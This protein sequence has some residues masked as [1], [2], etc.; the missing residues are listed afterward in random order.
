MV[1]TIPARK[2]VGANGM[3]VMP[4]ATVLVVVLALVYMFT[5]SAAGMHTWLL[6]GDID[7]AGALLLG[8]ALLFPLATTF[9]CRVDGISS[10]RAVDHFRQCSLLYALVI[11]GALMLVKGSESRGSVGYGI[12]VVVV[13]AGLIGVFM[14]ALTLTFRAMRAR[15]I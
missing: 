5:L 7:I 12:G 1:K 11:V 9:A 10:P 14:N 2:T 13:V 4:V 8:G 3:A 15:A 6:M